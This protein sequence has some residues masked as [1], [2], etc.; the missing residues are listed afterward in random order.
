MHDEL[1]C[2]FECPHLS[3][4]RLQYPALPF[5]SEGRVQDADMRKVFTAE[6]L[7]APLASFVHSIPA[8]AA[9]ER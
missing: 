8:I 6:N 7:V 2:V 4:T 1:H 9:E 3:H 5:G